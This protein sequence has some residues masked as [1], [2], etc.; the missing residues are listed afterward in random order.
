MIEA[1]MYGP[2]KAV[3]HKHGLYLDYKHPRPARNKRKKVAWTDRKGNTHD[4]DYVVEYGGSETVQGSPK[5]FIETAWRR[6]TKHSRNKAQEMQGAILPLA[7][8]YSEYSPFLGVALAGVFT[9]GSLQQLRS[10]GF[11]I[12]YFPYES[13]VQAFATVAIDAAF[14]ENTP[15]E[16][17]QAKVDS[18]Y[19]AGQGKQAQIA[20]A[21][22]RI[23]SNDLSAFI[24]E[25]GATL[26]RSLSRIYIATLHGPTCDVPTVAAAVDFIRNYDEGQAVT[27]FV[28]Y[29]VNV[30]YSN[31]D[32]ITGEFESKAK[33]IQFLEG[34]N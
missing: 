12:V 32:K 23:H 7:Q 4:L 28:R 5:A 8:T 34:L 33:A 15:D 20:N 31:G 25:L 18:Y 29:E 16:D 6:Y 22:K 2:L 13:I 11:G 17:L 19:A 9:D 10:N 1:M 30:R 24:G 3:A 21:L 14:D 27:G 26:T